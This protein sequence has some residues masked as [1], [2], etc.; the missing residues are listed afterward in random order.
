VEAAK[1]FVP[2]MNELLDNRLNPSRGAQI[3][4]ALEANA[5]ESMVHVQKMDER[6]IRLFE[7]SNLGRRVGDWFAMGSGLAGYYML[8][9]AGYISEKQQA[10]LLSDS[11]E[12]ETAG[13]FFQYG[14]LSEEP[15]PGLHE[16]LGLRLARLVLPIPRPEYLDSV[17]MRRFI[18]FHERHGAERMKFRKAVENATK[19]AADLKDP[20]AIKD[21]LDER[22]R[23]IRDALKDQ[24]HALDELRVG[25]V[26]S[27]CSVTVPAALG[28]GVAAVTANPVVVTIA[29]GVGMA[30]SLI[31]WLANVRAKAR[32]TVRNC[33]WHYLLSVEKE[34]NSKQVAA[35]AQNAFREFIFD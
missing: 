13:A 27:L 22:K 5:R 34:F 23:T 9:L 10:P 33:D 28:A 6:V 19:E 24:S 29:A 11:F 16:N 4:D 8:C 31:N 12:M 26:H 2:T 30:F 1:E 3:G 7:E 17:E 20:G 35:R 18:D 15:R 21:F 25:Q 14:R 32:Q